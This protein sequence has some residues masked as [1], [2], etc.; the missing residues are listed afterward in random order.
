KDAQDR[1][2]SRAIEAQDADLGSVEIRQVDVLEDDFPVVR[3][4]DAKHGI[5]DLVR[6]AAH[7]EMRCLLVAQG[8]EAFIVTPP[9]SP[10]SHGRAPEKAR[11]LITQWVQFCDGSTPG[12]EA[13]WSA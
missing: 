3:L 4:T 8:N 5:N 1:S 9:E 6:F 11:R 12:A 10:E 7:G 13:D 2:L